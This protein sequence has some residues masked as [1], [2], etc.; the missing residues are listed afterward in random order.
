[1]LDDPLKLPNGQVLKNRLA[2]AAMT[3]GLAEP[4]GAPSDALLRLYGLWARGGAGLLIT[5]N[6]AICRR[7][8]E[9]AGNVVIDGDADAPF[10]HRLAALAT[11]AKS[12]GAKVWVQ[13]SHAGRQ[14]PKLLNPTPQAPSAIP[15]R[16][17]PF[18]PPANPIA[19]SEAEIAQ[20]A[21]KFVRAASVLEE[22][23][24]DGVQVHA[25]HGY[26][27]SSFLSP[28]AN[29][30]HD[31]WGG[32]LGNRA[33]LLLTIVRRIRS[34]VSPT[35]AVSVKLN[36]A[37]FQRGGFEPSDSARVASWLDEEGVDLIEISGGSYEAPVMMGQSPSGRVRA[38]T[39]AREAYFVEFAPEIRR[40]VGRGALMITGGFRSAS[41]MREA[42]Q[43]GATD[44][45]GLGRPL[46]VDHAGAASLLAG[47]P[48]LTRIEEEL[49]IGGGMLSPQSPLGFVRAL[50]T[51]AVQAWYYEQ[52]DR[53]GDG[54]AVSKGH[55]T[56]PALASYLRRDRAK[57][58][59][60]TTIAS[61]PGG[62]GM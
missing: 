60:L 28:L 26:L 40:Q 41:A 32:S 47:A 31:K 62:G 21:D 18:V 35:F 4:D 42:L 27:L 1:M 15:M 54:Q 13:I 44:L 12:D 34:T 16:G 53:L 2:K 61:R 3:E 14:T 9:R 10:R 8:L 39:A 6:T 37:D 43:S 50:N 29:A 36:S 23:G 56:M 5:G 7:H 38:S 22:A 19:M 52:M 58:R 30:R 49:R 48:A 11:V 20:V 51:A 25:A 45:I 59:A 17:M 46:L 33:R 55:G 57:R 24:F